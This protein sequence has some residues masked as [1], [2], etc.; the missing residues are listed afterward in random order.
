MIAT[1]NSPVG[2]FDPSALPKADR[3][4]DLMIATGNSPVGCFDPSALPKAA[5]IRAAGGGG[6]LR[7]GNAR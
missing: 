3:I 6:G 5:R 4:R 7:Y 1:G 2:C